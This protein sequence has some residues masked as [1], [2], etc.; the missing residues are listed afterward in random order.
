VTGTLLLP[1]Q[2]AGA[3]AGSNACNKRAKQKASGSDSGPSTSRFFTAMCVQAGT[4]KATTTANKVQ[5]SALE[6]AAS[7]KDSMPPSFAQSG[8]CMLIAAHCLAATA[9]HRT[10]LT[11]PQELS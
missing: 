10:L 3:H 4:G 1:T 2:Q 7:I 9:Q 5:C 11:H 8:A 6:Q